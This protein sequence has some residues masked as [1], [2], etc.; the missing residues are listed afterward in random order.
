[1][2][3]K[4]ASVYSRCVVYGN[5]KRNAA[6]CGPHRCMHLSMLGRYNDHNRL[7]GEV[8]KDGAEIT[9]ARV[10]VT[11]GLAAGAALWG[12]ISDSVAPP[13]GVLVY[14]RHHK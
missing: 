1:M 13:R 3:F 12:P 11:V 10:R 2:T 6:Y 8:R 7:S 9:T 4:L 14:Y 5:V